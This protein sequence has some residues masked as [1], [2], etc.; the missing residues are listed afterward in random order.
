MG[1]VEDVQGFANSFGCKVEEFLISYLGF[2]LGDKYYSSHKWD[3]VLESV[4]SRMTSYSST[5]LSRGGKLVLNASCSS[6]PPCLYDVS[7]CGTCCCFNKLKLLFRNFLWNDREN[8]HKTHLVNWEVVTCPKEKGGLGVKQLKFLNMA[9][10]MNWLWRF[11]C[12]KT[13]FWRKIVAKEYGER[14]AGLVYKYLQSS[15]WL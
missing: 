14:S 9:L 13:V 6:S 2:P 5:D 4:E 10:I 7:L 3:V 1:Q 15:I 11:G 12:K 8:A